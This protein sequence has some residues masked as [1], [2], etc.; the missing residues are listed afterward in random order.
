MHL[1]GEIVGETVEGEEQWIGNES[2]E[3]SRAGATDDGCVSLSDS[4]RGVANEA[5]RCCRACSDS[6]GIE[7]N[8][9]AEKESHCHLLDE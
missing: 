4:Q 2:A 6:Q 9:A 1:A 8:N 3:T 5:E 7:H